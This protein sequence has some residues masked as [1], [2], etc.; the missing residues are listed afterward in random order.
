VPPD[1]PGAPRRPNPFLLAALLGAIALCWILLTPPGAGADE[2]THL[3]RT[4]VLAEGDFT[5]F[6]A[7]DLAPREHLLAREFATPEPGCY[8]PVDHPEIPVECSVGTQ[9]VSDRPD[10]QVTL[11]TTADNYPIWSHLIAAVGTWIPGI[12]AVWTAR[13]AS[14][15]V[16]VALVACAIALARPRSS[17]APAG[18][19]VALTPMAW[20]TFGTVNPSTITIGGA[21]AVWT[22]LASGALREPSRGEAWLLAAGWAALALP[23]RDGLIWACLVLAAFVLADGREPF[24]DVWR[25]RRRFAA[26]LA[27]IAAVTAI[28]LVWDVTNAARV[29]QLG[30]AAPLAV[31]AAWIVRWAWDRLAGRRVARAALVLA[32]AAVAALGVAAAFVVR[33]GGWDRPLADTVTGETGRHLTEAIGV[34]GWLDVPL[35]AAATFGWAVLVG[36]LAAAAVAAGGRSPALAASTLGLA[37]VTSWVFEMQEGSTYGRYWQGRYSLPLLV[38]V[39][40]VLAAR[41]RLA[42]A[43]VARFAGA[44]ALL[45]VNVAAWS[46]AR[47]WGVGIEGS[48]W[49]WDWNTQLTPLPPLL[50]LAAHAAATTALAVTLFGWPAWASSRRYAQRFVPASS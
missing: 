37:I 17:L 50:V 25:Q 43:S 29:A 7:R 2:P 40:I 18:V 5:D 49:P 36:V 31:V 11:T 38:G 34:L 19:L 13:A 35:P 22:V 14:S 20:A 47:R 3:V 23:R 42:N 4:G 45:I 28:V 1:D 32:L 26:P 21:V 8:A 12:S 48:Y 15:A 41:H 10:G 9:P 16:A 33:P 6:L 27:L 46:A 39:P 44:G 30:T 24:T